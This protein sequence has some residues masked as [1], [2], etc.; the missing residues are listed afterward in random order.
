VSKGK[1]R[2]W[3][4]S[5]GR[6]G[7]QRAKDKKLTEAEVDALAFLAKHFTPAEIETMAK[8]RGKRKEEFTPLQ[9]RLYVRLWALGGGK[10]FAPLMGGEQ[11][12]ENNQEATQ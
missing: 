12:S 8:A 9:R 6:P 2:T 1:R 10:V 7:K 11:S 4:R 5:G 3:W